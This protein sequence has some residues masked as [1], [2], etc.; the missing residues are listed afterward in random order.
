M[1]DYS[2]HLAENPR[3]NYV[4]DE[5]RSYLARGDEQYNLI[6]YPA[7]DSYSATNAATSG[8]FVLSES[9]LY[10]KEA[11]EESFDHLRPGGIIAA[12]F[13]EVNYDAKPNRTARYVAT[14][15][16]A[17][18]EMGVRNPADHIIVVTT[19]TQAPGA[20]AT[21]LV[22]PTPF[23]K[24]EVD[25]VLTRMT[26]L[27]ATTLRYA[28]GHAVKGDPVSELS[29]MPDRELDS[30]YDAYP[31]YIRPVT[32][33][34]P[35]FWHFK[36]FPDVIRTFGDAV[37]VGDPEVAIGERVLLLLLLVALLFAA[38]FL[39][40]P[41]LAI[42]DVWKKL[43]R[44]GISAVYFAALGLGFIFFEI[45][46]IQRLTLF[47]GYP[48]LS[49]TV[50][51]ASLLIFTGVGA[52]LSGRY[53][54]RLGQVVPVMIGA[55]AL[56]TVF[57][58]FGLPEITDAGLG[59]P[60]AARVATAFVVLAPLGICLGTF[61][62][63]G[64]GAVAG[65]TEF[66]REYVAWGWAVNGFASVVGAVLSTILAMTFGFRVVLVVA[67]VLYVV[68]FLALRT[69]LRQKESVAAAT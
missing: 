69:L 61:M 2:G 7:P 50:T 19:T 47:L 31:F 42:R 63:V 21:I 46:L 5:G 55:L 23:T 40:L 44:K 28:P 60:V 22:K 10:T 66:P 67:L 25:R 48:T 26:A 39:L 18:A 13:G 41:F 6:W 11:I 17:L 12:Q 1:A 68:A 52:L 45:T 14:A 65:L 32:D 49:L 58:L 53:A 36:Q 56:L 30:F 59:W 62:P 8:A 38:V 64:L 54:E 33:D 24:A 16:D 4:K 27:A 34:A 9:Y 20:L 43:P 37:S 15:R 3:V 35:F 57:Y 29:T 51:L